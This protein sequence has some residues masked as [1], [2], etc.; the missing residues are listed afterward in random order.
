MARRMMPSQSS[1][2]GQQ[3]AN[4]FSLLFL[5]LLWSLAFA[6]DYFHPLQSGGMSKLWIFLVAG[7]IG[8]L[9]SLMSFIWWGDQ[10]R[11][12]SGSPR[13]AAGITLGGIFVLSFYLW[14]EWSAVSPTAASGSGAGSDPFSPINVVAAVLAVVLAVM[15]LIATKS[16][17]DAHAEAKQARAD[18]LGALDI[19]LL[20]HANRLLERSQAAKVEADVLLSK[21]NDSGGQNEQLTR[22][23]N[24]CASVLF[25]LGN[26]FTGLHTWVLA[27][28]LTPAQDLCGKAAILRLDIA[29][30]ER[31]AQDIGH[32][33]R[34]EEQH[35]R[36][37][38]W[39]PAARLIKDMLLSVHA[40]ID[41]TSDVETMS[42]I[43]LFRELR[44]DLFRL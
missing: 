19:R 37:E 23:Y 36:I 16:A 24:L 10:S 6:W 8:Y 41:H 31:A 26:V 44:S 7:S 39:Q 43:N 4:R 11:A 14:Q 13:I 18:V 2:R 40:R 3:D 21:A 32:G 38:H 5:A 20:A 30:F 35:L 1:D 28:A 22:F 42:L 9:V 33:L 34:E 12:P 29:A 25:R 17:A 27:P 15:T